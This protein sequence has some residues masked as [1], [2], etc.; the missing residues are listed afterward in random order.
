MAEPKTLRSL[1]HVLIVG[2]CGFLGHHIVKLLIQKK[3]ASQ[4]SVLDLRTTQNRQDGVT[5]V[6]GDITDLE[7]MKQI[8]GRLKPDTVIHT[9]SP[10]F[11][12]RKELLY[13][14]NVDGTR[15][16][17]KAAQATGV[18]AFV[19]TSSASVI[20]DETVQ[21]VN[22]DER[23]PLVVGDRQPE[24]YTSTKVIDAPN[25]LKCNASPSLILSTFSRAT[26]KWPS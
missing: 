20:Y 3:L 9:A 15:N 10:H 23:W 26:R 1:R 5:Y 11:D 21:L 7:S 12:L 22:A 14:V 4:I 17:L 18:K 6:D 24:Y 25:I 19:Y 13:K 16:L 2:G 8:L